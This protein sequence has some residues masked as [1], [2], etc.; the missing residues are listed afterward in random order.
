M[1]ALGLETISFQPFYPLHG[2]LSISLSTAF[3]RGAIADL[4]G[5]RPPLGVDKSFAITDTAQSLV[6]G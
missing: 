5:I 3:Q 6:D 1:E 4:K 2:D